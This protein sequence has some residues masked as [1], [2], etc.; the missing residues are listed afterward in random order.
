[1]IHI[2][3]QNEKMPNRWSFYQMANQYIAYCEP[4]SL[5]NGFSVDKKLQNLPSLAIGNEPSRE[6]ITKVETLGLHNS[7]CDYK[8]EIRFNNKLRTITLWRLNGLVQIDIDNEPGC[9]IDVEKKC[10]VIL[11]DKPVDGLFNIELVTGPA[12]ILLLAQQSIFSLHASGVE[13]CR[14]QGQSTN[15]AFIAESGVGKSTLSISAGEY[16]KQCSDDILPVSISQYACLYNDFPQ[17]KLSGFTI[18]NKNILNNNLDY[19]FNIT[20]DVVEDIIIERVQSIDSVLAVIR[21]TVAARLF[22]PSLMK[23]HLEFAT[24]LINKVTVYRISYPRDIKQL[25]VLR[26]AIIDFIEQNK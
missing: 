5:L 24:A 19:I 4:V 20:S 2:V 23:K 22:E 6:S 3:R 7:H 14:Q 15:V 12:I 16:W 17:L 25:P 26:K 18:E 1:M 11:N 9:S 21:H 8:D 13:I 10:I